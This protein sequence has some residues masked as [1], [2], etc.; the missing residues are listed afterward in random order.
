M[1]GTICVVEDEPVTRQDAATL[2][3]EAGFSVVQFAS[4]DRALRY[5]ETHAGEVTTIFTDVRLPGTLNGLRL[6]EIASI[7]WPWVRVLVTS[8]IWDIE[9]QLPKAAIFLRKPWLPADILAL[10]A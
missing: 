8:G 4:A 6:A 1:S 3:Q 10:A 9:A 2:L 5:M 7:S